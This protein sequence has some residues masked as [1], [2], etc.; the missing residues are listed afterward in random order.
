MFLPAILNRFF[1]VRMIYQ[2]NIFD[3]CCYRGGDLFRFI[4]ATTS[5]DNTTYAHRIETIRGVGC[6]GVE[7]MRKFR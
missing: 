3:F 1:D 7:V 6:E 4:D 5:F 2:R